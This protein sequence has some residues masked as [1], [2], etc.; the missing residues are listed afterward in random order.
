MIC[1]GDRIS[2]PRFALGITNRHD[3]LCHVISET[4]AFWQNRLRQSKTRDTGLVWCVSIPGLIFLLMT[5]YVPTLLRHRF[6]V[7]ALEP[8][9][10]QWISRRFFAFWPNSWTAQVFCFLSCFIEQNLL[11][12]G[13]TWWQRALWICCKI[14]ITVIAGTKEQAAGFAGGSSPIN[15]SLQ[16]LRTNS[17]RNYFADVWQLK[18]FY[19]KVDVMMME[20]QFKLPIGSEVVDDEFVWSKA[21][22]VKLEKLQFC[23]QENFFSCV[24]EFTRLHVTR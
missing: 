4:K 8:T 7:L 17:S 20:V 13:R 22:Q 2:G 23:K 24:S 9:Q 1:N 21:I 11:C 10:L 18:C 16:H 12:W 15:P 19:E 6:R 3:L 5:R 14:T